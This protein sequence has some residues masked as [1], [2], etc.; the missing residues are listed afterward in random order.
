MRN[1]CAISLALMLATAGASAAEP[2]KTVSHGDHQVWVSSSE[3]LVNGELLP[4]ILD[5]QVEADLRTAL[6]A[7]NPTGMLHKRTAR[8]GVSGSGCDIV[9]ALSGHRPDSLN[10]L[11]DQ[12]QKV[13]V[14]EVLSSSNGFYQSRPATMIE[15]S[16]Q[17][18]LSGDVEFPKGEGVFV[19]THAGALEIEGV[20]YCAQDHR[21]R[22]PV[23]GKRVLVFT[24][25]SWDTAPSIQAASVFIEQAD[26][27]V[28]SPGS[29]D[30]KVDLRWSDLEPWIAEQAQARRLSAPDRTDNQRKKH[31]LEGSPSR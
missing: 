25:G 23:V 21:D 13:F 14:G 12:S 28:S 16:V 10:E 27:S 1:S 15:V 31:Q 3:V 7:T 22:G 20:R 9:K 24:T 17:E 18:H 6:A 29:S 2:P 11:R 19:A 8:E 30:K 4:G 26:G 5:P